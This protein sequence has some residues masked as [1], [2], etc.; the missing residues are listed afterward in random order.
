MLIILG[1]LPGVGKSEIA[2]ELARQLGAL[3]L[4]D[5]IEQALRD[6]GALTAPLYDAGYRV[7][8]AVAEDNLRLGR[9]VVADSVNPIRITRE[10]WFEVANRARCTAL[11]VEVKCSDPKEHQRRVEMRATDIPGLRLPTWDEVRSREYQQ[12]DHEHLVLDTAV[13][14]VEECV[15]MIREI[16]RNG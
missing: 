14:P 12:W 16:L 10:A 4:L 15:N 5:S 7:A 6:S 1:G 9:T 13:C 2:R 3:Y 11:E 8:Y